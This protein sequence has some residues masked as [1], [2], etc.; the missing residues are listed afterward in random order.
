M[1]TCDV[2]PVWVVGIV[3]LPSVVACVISNIDKIH[4][5][6]ELFACLLVFHGIPLT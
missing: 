4:L 5:W 3:L 6:A 2:E 1:L